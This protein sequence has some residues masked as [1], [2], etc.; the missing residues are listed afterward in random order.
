MPMHP[1]IHR[2]SSRKPTLALILIGAALLML[3]MVLTAPRQSLLPVT[4]TLPRPLS[5]LLA[6]GAELVT[7][8]VELPVISHGRLAGYLGGVESVVISHATARI[9]SDLT[10]AAFTDIDPR[11]MT[12]TL[13]LPLPGVRSV[14]IEAAHHQTGRYGLWTV[15]PFGCREGDAAAEA[16]RSAKTEALVAANE[17]H[18]IAQARR[19]AD[20][21]LTDLAARAG[22]TLTLHTPDPLPLPVESATR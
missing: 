15:L 4:Q 17:P 11:K 9:G 6:S 13:M 20:T 3:L 18:L 16:L 1:P 2:P 14:A 19:H 7:L 8:H 10:T 21:V 22:W 5:A 12:A